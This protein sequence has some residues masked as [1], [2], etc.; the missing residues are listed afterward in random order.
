ML[1]WLLGGGCVCV[2]LCGGLIVGGVRGGQNATVCQV[3]ADISR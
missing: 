1:W 2:L 3:F